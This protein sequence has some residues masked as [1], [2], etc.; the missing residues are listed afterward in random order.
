[1]GVFEFVIILVLISTLGK[2]AIA[3]GG[4]LLNHVGDYF[5]ELAAEKR[6]R[7]ET[8]ESGSPLPPEVI[9]E[10]ELR[11]ARIEDRLDFLEELRAPVERR[12]ISG[13]GA[14]PSRG[15]DRSLPL[16]EEPR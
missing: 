6:T 2:A 8:L 12:A 4:P 7:R 5:R 16:D 10:L 9:E 15:P 1:M 13:G 11:L 14:G 3:I